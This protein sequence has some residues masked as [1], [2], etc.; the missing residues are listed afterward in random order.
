MTTT[1][2]S[3]EVTSTCVIIFKFRK[4]MANLTCCLVDVQTVL[5]LS[6]LEVPCMTSNGIKGARIQ[7]GDGQVGAAGVVLHVGV[8][9]KFVNG[10]RVFDSTGNGAP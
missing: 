5:S 9:A 7:A 3:A 8:G 4:N 2:V 6:A 10:Q 1:L